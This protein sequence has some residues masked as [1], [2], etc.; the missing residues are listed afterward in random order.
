MSAIHGKESVLTTKA[1]KPIG[2]YS[3]GIRTSEL[4]F[5]SGQAGLDPETGKLVEGGIE[6]QTR[7]ALTNIQNVLESAGSGLG[8]VV[9]TTV[10]LKS[11]SDFPRM[12]AVYAEFFATQ[13]PA[14]TTIAAA[15]LPL[16][17]L[18]EIEAIALRGDAR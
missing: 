14:R 1:P 10:F 9:K 18:V 17:A 11:M 16:N 6:A 7:Q 12:N 15:E 4:V 8:L 3:Q 5:A 13:P 2:P